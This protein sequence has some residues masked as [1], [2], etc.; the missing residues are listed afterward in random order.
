MLYTHSLP[1]P[2]PFFILNVYG[3]PCLCYLS[4]FLFFV[5]SFNK[6]PFTIHSF[7]CFHCGPAHAVSLHQRR[8]WSL[9]N[10]TWR[11]YNSACLLLTVTREIIPAS[12]TDNASLWMT[13]LFACYD[14]FEL[15]FI[16]HDKGRMSQVI[17]WWPCDMSKVGTPSFFFFAQIWHCPCIPTFDNQVVLFSTTTTTT[18]NARLLSCL[19]WPTPHIRIATYRGNLLPPNRKTS[20]VGCKAPCDI[21][22]H[23]NTNYPLFVYLYALFYPIKR[24]FLWRAV[25]SDLVNKKERAWTSATFTPR[26]SLL[27]LSGF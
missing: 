17:C 13:F 24:A 12:P 9:L 26:F 3:I 10:V 15:H 19:F 21:A 22:T 16:L 6:I 27:P 2:H 4:S 25:W 23:A 7:V 14:D 1:P 20:M 11:D 8:W 18:T 5:A